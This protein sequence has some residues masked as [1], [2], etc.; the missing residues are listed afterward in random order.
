MAD[1]KPATAQETSVVDAEALRLLRAVQRMTPQGGDVGHALVGGTIAA[2]GIAAVQAAPASGTRTTE[3]DAAPL[4]RPDAAAPATVAALEQHP[5]ADH[6][7]V[8]DTVLPVAAPAGLARPA[9]AAIPAGLARLAVAPPLDEAVPERAP[10][11]ASVV[12]TPAATVPDASATP[13]RATGSPAALTP[14]PPAAEAETAAASPAAPAAPA[15]PDGLAP[16]AT[17]RPVPADALPADASPPLQ[18]APAPVSPPPPA[19]DPVPPAEPGPAPSGPTP[20]VEPGPTPVDPTPPVEPAPTPLNPTPPVESDPTPV[21]PTPPVEPEP[22]PVDPTPPAEPE[23]T[24]VDPTPPAEPEP[25]PVDPTPPVEPEPTPVDPI[26]PVEPEPT[27]V[28]P[29]PPAEPEPTPVDPIPPVEPEPTPVDPIPPVEPE[30]TPVDPIPPVEPEPTPVEPPPPAGPEPTPVDPTPPVEPD[31]TP[32][33]PTPPVEPEPT[34]VDPIP[35]VE[36]E[37][38]PV[39]PTPPAEPEPTPVEPPP[40]A[41]PEPTPVDPTPPVEPDPT[42]VDPIPPVEPEPEPTPVDPIPP[43]KPEPTPIDPTPPI[44]PEP[45]PVDPTPPVEPEPTPVDPTPP[46]EPDPTTVDPTPPVEPEPTPVDPTPPVEPEPTPVDPAPPVEPEPPPAVPAPVAQIPLVA[47]DSAQGFEDAAIALHLSASVADTDGAETLVL[48]LFGVPDGASLSAGARQADGSWLLAAGDLPG[49]TLTPP[50]DFAGN[51]ELTLRATARE[52]NGDAASSEVPFVVKVAPV[53]DGAVLAG[54]AAGSEDQ[55]IALDVQFGQ[56]SDASESWDATVLVQGV[57]PGAALNQGEALGDG[58]WVVSQAALA[59]GLVAIRPPA[60]ASGSIALRLEAVLRDA[61][62]EGASQPVSLALEVQVAAV[63]DA[64]LVRAADAAGLEDG[65]VALDLSAALADTDGSESLSVALLGLPEEARLSA[66][67]RQADGSWSLLATE[68]DGLR[69]WL[70]ADQSGTLALTLRAT[71][72][73]ADGDAATSEAAF[74][75]RIAAVSDGAVLQAGGEGDEDSWIPLRGTLALR[76][77]DGSERF[78]EVLVVRGLPEGAAL[79]HGH[80]VSPGT[81]EVPLAAFQAGGLAVRPPADSDADLRLLFTVT[82][83]DQGGGAEDRR[84][85]E[86]EVRVVVR[87]VADAPLLTVADLQGQEDVPLRLSGLGGALRDTDGSETLSFL[88]DGLPAGASLTAGTRQPDGSWRLTAA[89]LA[90]AELT[91]P[92]NLS[93][94]FALTLTAVATEQGDSASSAAT[95]AG[96]TLRLDPVAD[97]GSIGGGSSGWEDSPI[98]LRPVFFTPDT[99]GSEQWAAVSRLSGVPEGASIS[100]GRA[101]A[102]GEW[103]VPTAALRAGEVFLT[104]PPDS[105]ADIVLTITTVL[106]DSG[107]GTTDSRVV[108]GRHTVAVGAVADAPLVTVADQQGSEDTLLRLAGLGGALRDT[109]G[110]ETLSFRLSGVPAGAN[111]SAG[112][113]QADGSWLLSP[114]QLATLSM[115]PPS[116]FSG[117]FSMTLTA[118]ATEGADG[119]PSAGTSAS[120]TVSLDPV[121]DAGSI[122]GKT[123]GKEDTAIVLRP[124]FSTPDTDGS[125]TWA[126]FSQVAGVPAGAR[127]SQ[128]T[129]LSAGVWQ[130]STAA[131]RA[132]QVSVTP[133]HDSDADFT[134]RITTTLSDTGNGI[135]V[136]RSVTGSYAVT[137]VAVADAP[138][139]TAADSS[140]LEDQWIGLTL[141]A[142]LRDTDGSETLSVS[143]LG[144]PAGASLSRGSRAADGS[145]TLGAGDLSGLMLLPPKDFSGRIA[146][147]LK[148]VASDHDNSTATTT[149]AFAVQVAGVA[150]TPVLRTGGVA[151]A[152]DSAIAL[153]ASA[154]TTDLDGSE[155]IVAFRLAGVPAGAVVRAGGTVLVAEADGSILVR[156]DTMGS[157]SITPPR[158]SDRDFVLRISAISAEPNGSRA[159]SPPTDLAVRVYAVADAPVVAGAGGSGREDSPVLL[160]LGAALRDTDGSETLSVLVGGLP[161]GARL[162]A[163]TWR[164]DG[165]WSLTAEEART[166]SLLPPADFSGTIALRVTAIA[167]ESANGAQARTT[168]ILPV[169]VEGVVDTPAVGGMDGHSGDWGVMRGAEDQPIA[170]RLDPGLRDRDGSEQVVGQVV[171]GGIPPGAVLRLADGSVVA[172]DADGLWRIDAARMAGVTLQP[173]PDSDDAIA[174]TVRMTL[175]DGEAWQEVGG[176]MLVEPAGVADAPLLSAA[177]AAGQGGDWV[178]L[179]VDARLADTDGSETL[180]LWVRDLPDG[181]QLSAGRPAGAQGWLVPADALPGLAI[182]APAG[183][184][185][186]VSLRL[187]AMAEERGGDRAVTGTTLRLHVA[188]PP[189][190]GTGDGGTGD[191]GEPSPTVPLPPVL[192]ASAGAGQEDTALALHVT[193]AGSALDGHA[194]RLGLRVEGV[195]AGAS[196]SAGVRDP[197]SGAWIVAPAELDGLLLHP[198]AD[199]SGDIR[200]LLRGLA[201]QPD[202]TTLSTEQALTLSVAPDTD[203][204]RIT[205]APGAAREGTAVALN[206]QVSPGDADGS[207]QLLSVTLSGLP[208]G[209]R[210]AEGEGITDHGDGRWSVATAQLGTVRLLPPE[211]FSGPLSLTVS[212]VTQ[213]PGAASRTTA[214]V[215]SLDIAP[216]ADAPVLS[217]QDAHGTE[218]QAVP[219]ALSA[220]LAD[221]DGSEIL[222]LVLEGLPPGSRL[223]AGINNGDGSWTL[224]PAQLAGLSLSPPGDWSGRMALTLV[225]HAM[226]GADGSTASSRAG[227]AVVVDAVADTPLIEVAATAAGLEDGVLPL[228]LRAQLLDLD[229]SETLTLRVSGVPA[230]SRFT[231]GTDHGDGSWTI[232]GEAVPGLGFQPPRDFSGTLRLSFTAIGTEADGSSASSA[233]HDM[234]LTVRPVADAP[235]LALSAATSQ[236]DAPLALSIVAAPADADGSETLSRVLLRGVPAG[237]ML[238]AG[239]RQAD[240][241]WL[242]LPAQLDNL[243]LTPPAHFSGTLTLAVTAVATERASGE[244]ASTT[245]MLELQVAP[246]ADA[247]L[248]SVRNATGTEDHALELPISAALVDTDGS[249]RLLDLRI[250]GLPAGFALSAGHAEPDGAWSVAASDLPGLRLLPAA[251]WNGTL[252]LN[253]QAGSEEVGNGARAFSSRDLT[254]TLAAV[255]DAPV[256]SLVAA[257]PAAGGTAEAPVLAQVQAQDVDSPQLGGAVVTLSGGQGGDHLGFDGFNLHRTDGHLM[258]GDTGIELLQGGF[259]AGSGRLVLHGAAPP[260]TYAAVLQSM[261]LETAA[262]GGLVAGERS[263]SV[264][265]QDSG[266]AES[267]WHSVTLAVQPPPPPV[268]P[269]APAEPPAAAL[270]WADIALDHGGT[271]PATDW[272]DALHVADASAL[273]PV[274]DL[275]PVELGL[276]PLEHPPLHH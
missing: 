7:T 212:A 150:D 240:G 169:V 146:L 92:A 182:R 192:L 59:A 129:E 128:G 234:L 260:E 74:T 60:D 120:F 157:L 11:V 242:L 266:G 151:G 177:D 168:A 210:I 187:D 163:G 143:L 81:W 79:S 162:S 166:V 111:L 250:N 272:A 184:S 87:A 273:P 133:P 265:L 55:W 211:H 49:L 105:D 136:S 18:H 115:A 191:G 85:T 93:G 227:F 121:V 262:P 107:N 264:Q 274:A 238:S 244:E 17:P 156:P 13:R 58:R 51:I 1:P 269:D 231:A 203:A 201:V 131:L 222:S 198:P 164:G 112:T 172:P 106:T 10:P 23:P 167:Q 233:T 130:V 46:V 148:A 22:T 154:L 246:V 16:V 37:P 259:D 219:L 140:G 145:W 50:A 38:T 36:P 268:M 64:P 68:L 134:L 175:R 65:S 72:H 237:A 239:S 12:P 54:M 149:A 20:P 127:L 113:R 67:T 165:Q 188:P 225:A 99:D 110:S 205:A 40:P 135:T 31:P 100:H 207:E 42:P 193:L 276:P 195:P 125:E 245:G 223:S 103:E 48:N 236:E 82:T 83:I 118:I 126:A 75:V 261:V 218:D 6:A 202:G 241:S 251:D 186:D 62:G 80:E 270:P 263:V 98:L 24:P 190:G 89:E 208:P 29:T 119:R 229:G 108:S 185:G 25:T 217:V 34:P 27:P 221:R 122:S 160:D 170:L 117:R 139:A 28:D 248:L 138:V 57:P 275:M 101:V 141:G 53:V 43:V 147:T 153:H 44:E 15:M 194:E 123:S 179:A 243:T 258:I 161:P 267:T 226:E 33:D 61:D 104:P 144:V 8:A 253:V 32:V 196:L 174:L 84:D 235:L 35:P 21:D 183:F 52:A 102:P 247:P 255:N 114:A 197:D 63:A 77:T 213:D 152:E 116:Q 232:P 73:E 70:P 97:A 109:D 254:V 2:G 159:E 206:L 39:D 56:S 3:A 209:A 252:H 95:S 71:A 199:F 181:F 69:L 180:W 249:E 88:L 228:D 178:P 155:S 66:G 90:V 4:R 91:P 78:G 41:G 158:D 76:D 256:L 45:T 220:A 96:F 94:S 86:A 47:A 200:L 189:G 176:R 171:L 9:A 204:A 137:V 216:V 5:V 19:V 257:P 214:V 26:P 30:P 224:T 173:P 142:A 14:P 132:G 230:G 124:S 271:V 215:L